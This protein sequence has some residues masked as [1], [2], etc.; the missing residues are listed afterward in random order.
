MHL[1]GFAEM[2]QIFRVQI[3]QCGVNIHIA[4]QINKRIFRA[5]I[6]LMEIFKLLL[7]QLRDSVR[8]AAGLK[9][10]ASVGEQRLH[11]LVFQKSVGRRI[12]A[13]HLVINNAVIAQLALRA[14]QIIM[15]A[16][17]AQRIFIFVKQRIKHR[18]QINVHQIMKILGVAAGNGINR[19]I[20]IGHGIQESIQRALD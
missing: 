11:R 7:R 12:N 8:I 2:R 13:L 5:V 16:L 20:G 14:F 4:I 3:S 19:F 17:L 10:V 9:A 18:V 1:S 6:S 15:P